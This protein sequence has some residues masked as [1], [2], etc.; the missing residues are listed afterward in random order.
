MISNQTSSTIAPYGGQLKNLLVSAGEA[1]TLKAHASH[2]PSIQI[3]PHSLC[4]LE[5]LASGAF[6]PL[7]RFMGR[8]DYQRVMDEMRL[9][10]GTLFP[11]PVTLPVEPSP[12]LHLDHEIALRGSAYELLGVMTVEELYPT[13]PAGSDHSGIGNPT[14]SVN[15]SGSLRLLNLPGH[16]DFPELRL[17]P[18]QVR[19]RLAEAGHTNVI[20]YQPD[21]TVPWLN[22]LLEWIAED[23]EAALLLQLA[24]GPAKPGDFETYNRVRLYKALVEQC[25]RPEQVILSLLPL[26]RRATGVRET[27]WQALI[28]RNY[29][30]SRL[31]A[32]PSVEG[33]QELGVTPMPEPE[34]VSPITGPA[35]EILAGME[36]P[37]HQQGVCIWFTGLSGSGKSTTAE[38]LT[39]LVMEHGRRVTVLDGDVVR[40]HL[41]KGLGFSKED[42]DTNVRRIGFVASELVRIGGVVIC[43]VVSPYRAA[44]GDARSMVGSDHFIEVFVDTPLEVCE[45]RDVKGMYAKA[46][47]GALKGFTGIDDPYEPPEHPEIR[48]DTVINTPQENAA[49]IIDYLIERG[50]LRDTHNSTLST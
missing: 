39:Y 40:T 24:V 37:R 4:D 47:S 23:P 26:A 11:M 18:A 45:S 8:A 41:S 22:A 7:E 33:M 44:R 30:A 1:G 38:I 20:A 25:P 19:V 42:R 49:R 12:D 29:G 36:P 32:A 9:A 10:D 15:I 34:Q 3:A 13:D 27:L 5:M 48:L 2:L 17:T 14:A 16:F 28:A 46:R 6:S 35:A 50:F 21:Q 31:A 43:S